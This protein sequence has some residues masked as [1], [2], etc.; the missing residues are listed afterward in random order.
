MKHGES[1][2][3]F[4]R[5]GCSG[6]IGIFHMLD[7]INVT[8]AG[9]FQINWLILCGMVAVKILVSSFFKAED[10]EQEANKVDD[11]KNYERIVVQMR[12]N[13]GPKGIF[14]KVDKP[15]RTV[16]KSRTSSQSMKW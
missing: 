5:S 8:I 15:V 4:R 13:D 10:T 12:L 3:R 9:V 14:H 6:A 2:S 7:F 16:A 11:Y 1:L